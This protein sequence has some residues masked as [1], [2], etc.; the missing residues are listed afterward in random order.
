M[1][2]FLLICCI[3]CLLGSHNIMDILSHTADNLENIAGL[4]MSA[5]GTNVCTWDKCIQ[6]CQQDTIGTEGYNCLKCTMIISISS[7]VEHRYLG[8]LKQLHYSI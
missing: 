3:I 6:M 8:L 5:P 2:K 1:C 7:H 4:R